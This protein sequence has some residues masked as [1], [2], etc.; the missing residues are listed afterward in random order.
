M[1]CFGNSSF[2]FL[3]LKIDV[4]IF[5]FFL[6]LQEDDLFLAY[7]D[8]SFPVCLNEMKMFFYWLSILLYFLSFYYL[9]LLA[10]AFLFFEF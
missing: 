5:L 7:Y 1:R 4:F 6:V 10:N 2:E 3:E 9:D 8:G